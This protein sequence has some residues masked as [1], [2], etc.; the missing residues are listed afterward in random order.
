MRTCGRRLPLKSAPRSACSAR[1]WNFRLRGSFLSLIRGAM[2]AGGVRVTGDRT[3][4]FAARE[5]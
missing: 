2:T 5:R 4:V 3:P 1:T